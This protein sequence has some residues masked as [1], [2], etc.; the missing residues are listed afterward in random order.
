MT[1]ELLKEFKEHSIYRLERN[2]PRIATCLDQL[3]EDEVWLRANESSNSVGNLIL[4]LC[5]NITQYIISSIGMSV[6]S[7]I[8]H[9]DIM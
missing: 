9:T 1:A 2:T 8:L 5:G 4:H 7:S 6:S 3:S